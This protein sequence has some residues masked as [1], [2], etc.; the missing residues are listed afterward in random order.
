MLASESSGRHLIAECWV[1]LPPFLIQ[2]I[3][4]WAQDFAFLTSSW[5]LPIRLDVY[6]RA[7][8]HFEKCCNREFIALLIGSVNFNVT[9]K[10]FPKFPIFLNIQ[11]RVCT[12]KGSPHRNMLLILDPCKSTNSLPCSFDYKWYS[13]CYSCRL[14]PQDFLTLLTPVCIIVVWLN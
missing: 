11:V 2:F 14:L 1:S 4:A 10:H 8:S 7:S 6:T 9:P 12:G 3:W 13:I 5:I